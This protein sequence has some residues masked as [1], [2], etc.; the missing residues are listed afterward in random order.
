MAIYAKRLNGKQRAWCKKYERETTF[1]PLFQEDL[2][3]GKISFE[4]FAKKNIRWF[5]DWASDTLLR[6]GHYPQKL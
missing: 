3:S 6:I 5:E 2:D 4:E 1:E